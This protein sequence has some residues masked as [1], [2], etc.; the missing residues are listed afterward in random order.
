MRFFSFFTLI[1]LLVGCV[2]RSKFVDNIIKNYSQED[3]NLFYEANYSSSAHPEL[4]FCWKES[5]KIFIEDSTSPKFV[6]IVNRVIADYNSIGLPIHIEVVSK[7]EE[8]NCILMFVDKREI[9]EDGT[10]AGL[11]SLSFDAKKGIYQGTIK[12][13]KALNSEEA[14]SGLYHEFFHLL[15]FQG[16]IT[17]DTSSIVYPFAL[18]NNGIDEQEKRLLVM[19][20]SVNWPFEY[21]KEK[22]EEDFSDVLFVNRK[23]DVLLNYM[24]K[25]K[26]NPDFINEII[27]H[28]VFNV[29]GYKEDVVFKFPNNVNVSSNEGC[30]KH[31]KDSL[32]ECI[33][34]LNDISTTF[35]L[36]YSEKQ[37]NNGIVFFIINDDTMPK[38]MCYIENIQYVPARAY[39]VNDISYTQVQ[40][41]VNPKSSPLPSRYLEGMLYSLLVRKKN[42]GKSSLHIFEENNHREIKAFYKDFYNFYN[43]PA[44]IGNISKSELESVLSQ[45]KNQS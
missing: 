13:D 36:H 5:I 20:Y 19:L 24:I 29:N 21:S 16:H 7:M 44:L 11:T 38:D 22:F 27:K 45:L 42:A 37:L 12:I 3:I 26:I 41:K 34:R 6:T 43:S 31:V 28:D 10:C 18:Y 23:Q 32:I 15:G 25:D 4:I 30:P 33:Q 40:I 9:D 8:A 1:F 2:D 35:K 14:M 39:V 17:S